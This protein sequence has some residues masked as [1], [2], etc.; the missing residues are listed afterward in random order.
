[1]KINNIVYYI[2]TGILTFFLVSGALVY[3]AGT[4]RIL[5]AFSNEM[6]N[7]HNAIGFPGW[8]IVPMA[9]MK[10]CGAVALWVPIV[11]KWLREWAYA[12]I[13]FNLLLAI[14]AHVFNPINPEDTDLI[15]ILPFIMVI[16]SR[17]TLFKKESNL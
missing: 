5:V 16:V 9:I 2:S 4:E 12:G 15:A 10:L 13:F 14:G 1:M 17:V 6:S 3:L 7:G 11:P 8:L